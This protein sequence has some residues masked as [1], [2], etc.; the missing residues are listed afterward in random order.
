MGCGQAQPV[1]DDWVQLC[2]VN[3][4]VYCISAGS[5]LNRLKASETVCGLLFFWLSLKCSNSPG[6]AVERKLEKNKKENK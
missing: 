3:E 4:E 2:V 6:K 5:D 1:R